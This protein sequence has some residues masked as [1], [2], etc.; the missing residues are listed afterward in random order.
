M[1]RMLVPTDFSAASRSGLRFAIQWTK[2]QEATIIFVHVLHLPRPTVWSD[3]QFDVFAAA[4]RIRCQKKLD[5]FVTDI[6]RQLDMTDSTNT[7]IILEGMSPDIVIADYCRHHPEID[8]ICMGTRGAGKLKKIFGTHTGN[9]IVHA[10]IPVIAVQNNYRM[11]PITRLLYATDL[12]NCKEELEK[13]VAFASP[14]AV[15]VSVL[16]FTQPGEVMIDRQ[17]MEE[18]FRKESRYDIKFNFKTADLAWSLV[19][20]LQ[21][22]IKTYK[23]SLVVMFTNR[24]RTLFQKIFFSSSAEKL[25]FGLK[26]PLL[27]FGKGS[28]LV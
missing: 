26:A 13:V 5:R 18:V 27:V 3:K 24:D 4:E 11:K 20:N 17:L 16:H 15:D 9:L 6:Y 28:R 23:P 2:Q 8:Y 22:E 7:R 10:P 19:D 25:A 21:R 1:I 12:H 14:L